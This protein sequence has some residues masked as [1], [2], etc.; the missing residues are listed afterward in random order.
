MGWILMRL[1]SAF[2]D[3][4][5]IVVAVDCVHGASRLHIRELFNDCSSPRLILLRDN[6]DVTFGGVAPEPSTA[7]MREVVR[8]LK[9]RDEPFKLGAIIDPDGDRIRFTDGKRKS[10]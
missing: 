9:E 1:L 7:N 2:L 4:K 10:A 8:V 5:D 6:A 3:R